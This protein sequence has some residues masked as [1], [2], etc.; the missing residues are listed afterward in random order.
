MHQLANT[1]T[2]V[3]ILCSITLLFCVVLSPTF[4]ALY[5][6]AGLTDIMDGWIA[7]K[8]NTASEFGARLDTFADFTFLT[9]CAIKLLPIM[10]ISVCFYT[11]VGVIAVIKLFNVIGGY[12]IHKR[13]I[14]LH[15]FM[16]K[17]T[18][19]LLFIFP[20]TINILGIKIYTTIV[21]VL[22]TFTAIQEGYYIIKSSQTIS[23]EH[24]H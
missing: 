21:C 12:L 11:W 19:A 9:I 5:I 6:L 20:L 8:T 18:G 7:R 4:Y 1:I 23:F 14:A 2:S 17:L 13:F 15:T 22:A 10:E 16:N 24:K 3:R